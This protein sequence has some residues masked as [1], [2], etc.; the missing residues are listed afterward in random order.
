MKVR[1]TITGIEPLLMHSDR[2]SDPLDPSAMALREVTKKRVK[3]DDDHREMARLEWRGSLY[4]SERSGVH[5]PG[6]NIEK[7][8]IEGARISRAGRQVERGLFVLT[9][10]APLSYDGPKEMDAL[11]LDERFRDRRSVGVGPRRVMRTRPIFPDWSVD[12]EAE[13]D[14][15]VLG[16][17]E[18]RRIASEAGRQIGLGDFRPRYGRFTATVESAE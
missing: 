7:C 6:R 8:F 15:S 10:E 16:M 1:I 3:T 12:V 4:W 14:T 9:N 2:L 5:I 18:L 13:L 11:W 17:E